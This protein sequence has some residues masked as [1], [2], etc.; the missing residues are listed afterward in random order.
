MWCRYSGL[1]VVARAF[2]SGDEE[3]TRKAIR[4]AFTFSVVL[5]VLVSALSILLAPFLL[6]LTGC[7]EEIYAEAILYLRIYLG[8]VMFMVIYN[9]GTGILRAVGDSA[10]PLGILAVSSCLNIALATRR[11][12]SVKVIYAAYPV[13]WAAAMLLLLVYTLCSLR[14]MWA[15][16]ES[17]ELELGPEFFRRGRVPNVSIAPRMFQN[18]T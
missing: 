15:E 7:N 8:G 3:K 2:G 5:G 13:G 16:T 6:S 12:S 11:W 10:G 17:G 4:A 14:R 9:C 18:V 1:V